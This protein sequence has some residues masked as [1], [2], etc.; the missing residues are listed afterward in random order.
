MTSRPD[1]YFESENKAS[2]ADKRRLARPTN[3]K[4]SNIEAGIPMRDLFKALGFVPHSDAQWEYCESPARFNVPT[5]G[6]RW[7]K[8]IASGHK[9]T[10]KSFKPESYN[11]IVG[12]TYKLGEKEF[13]VTYRDYEKLGLL[14]YCRKQYAVNQ[15][16][17]RIET[18]FKSVIEVVSAEKPDSLLGEGL[19]HA[20]M[21]EAAKH[22]RNIWEQYIEPALS[23][24]LGSADF[25]STPQ[26][27]NW[28]HGLFTLGQDPSHTDYASWT[29]PSWTNPIRFPGGLNNAEIMRIRA[30]V[31][32]QY[33][34]QEYGALFTS[35]AG[36]IY[37]E[38]DDRIHIMDNYEFHPE[39]P[40]YVVFDF[41][42]ANPFVALDIQ[43]T[44]SEDV[45]VWREYYARFLSTYDHGQALKSRDN[46]EGYHIDGM[47]GD[48]RG[49]D[50][51]ATLSPILG[52]VA[53]QDVPWKLGVE[54]IKRLLKVDPVTGEPKFFVVRTCPNTARQM[55]QLHVKER[56]NRQ[57]VQLDEQSG[58]G[59]IQHKVDDHAA[60][61]VRYFIGPYFVLGAGS[62]LEDVYGSNYAGSESEDFLKLHSKSAVT[63]G[64][65]GGRSFVL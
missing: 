25:P 38:W 56:T 12:P 53:S 2:A 37:D 5:C 36:Q 34:E 59:N 16:N 42:F 7:G 57:K 21:S 49:A 26:G 3:S 20:T 8:S 18:P 63:L 23:D 64:D 14:K 46:P 65:M 39:W 17:M 4:L 61:A 24:L 44:P 31:S 58:D 52:F 45:I 29:F 48:P 50:E 51:I 60:D 55:G 54:A 6:R 10:H 22:S 43:V 32:K 13:R 1:P 41:G 30:T 35:F 9:I 28:Y 19:S 27:F 33:F 11:W 47:W 62:H 15:G 40:N